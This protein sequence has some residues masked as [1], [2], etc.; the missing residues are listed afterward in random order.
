VASF[1]EVPF[2]STN[3][4][5]N[6]T[7]IHAYEAAPERWGSGQLFLV[8]SCYTFNSNYTRAEQILYRI[9][10]D[11][12]QSKMMRLRAERALG[13]VCYKRGDSGAAERQWLMDT[14]SPEQGRNLLQLLNSEK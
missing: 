7:I 8:A 6:S 10:G 13:S 4:A 14:L 11:T 2:E 12:N 5:V 9:A 1:V 3:S